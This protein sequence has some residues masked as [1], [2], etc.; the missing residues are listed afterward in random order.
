VECNGQQIEDKESLL[1]AS[2]APNLNSA[3]RFLR[4]N[5]TSGGTGGSDTHSHSNAWTTQGPSA[6]VNAPT[7][8]GQTVAS[9]THTHGTNQ[10]TST[11]D[12][13]PLYY[14]VVWII[15]IK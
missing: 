6:T 13:K 2:Y 12:T 5:L 1:N 3:N 9:P 4:G 11:A 7:G 8:I 15:R 14:D 10:P